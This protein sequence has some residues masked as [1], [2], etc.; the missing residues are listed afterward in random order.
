MQAPDHARL[1]RAFEA[2]IQGPAPMGAAAALAGQDPHH[3]LDPPPPSSSPPSSSGPAGGAAPAASRQLPLPPQLS[4]WLAD[5][6]RQL[7][8]LPPA[9]LALLS[10]FVELRVARGAADAAAMQGGLAALAGELRRLLEEEA[11][12]TAE[13]EGGGP[14]QGA[15]PPSRFPFVGRCGETRRR[16]ESVAAP[17]P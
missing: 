7:A 15:P 2:L 12:A 6:K 17:E 9:A 1:L 13:G 3:L 10:R 5:S 16:A 4:Q 14:R 11:A 8:A